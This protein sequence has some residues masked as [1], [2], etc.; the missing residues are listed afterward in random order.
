MKNKNVYYLTQEGFDNLK[1][2]HERLRGSDWP[3]VLKR[4]SEARELGKLE[5]NQ[6]LEEAKSAKDMIEGRLLEL[7]DILERAEIIDVTAQ[8]N[9]TR[10]IV[11]IGS[12]VT[13]EIQGAE[14]TFTLVGSIEADPGKGKISHESPVGKNLMGLKEGDIVEIKLPHATFEY[15]IIKIHR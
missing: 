5:D 13:V 4:V 8:G 15:K 1:V 6:E 2:E 9:R 3:A 11:T 10:G 7:E 14:Q 12:T